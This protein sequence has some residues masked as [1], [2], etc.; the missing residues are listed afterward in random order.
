MSDNKGTEIIQTYKDNFVK[1]YENQEPEVILTVSVVCAETNKLA[2]ETTLS[3]LIW[4]IQ[5]E[6]LEDESGVPS[7]EAA[8][9]YELTDKEKKNQKNETTNDYR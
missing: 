5:K 2:E 1:R 4:S 8:K 7:I 3:G 9:R 6:K